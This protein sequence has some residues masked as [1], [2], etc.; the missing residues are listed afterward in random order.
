MQN[1]RLIHKKVPSPKVGWVKVYNQ[2]LL[3]GTAGE[4]KGKI[5][6]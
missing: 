5:L 2:K 1:A 4:V 3:F 6:E